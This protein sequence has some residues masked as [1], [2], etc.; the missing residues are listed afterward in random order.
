MN[1]FLEA[2]HLDNPASLKRVIGAG[3]AGLVVLLAPLIERYG[4]QKPSDMQLEIF[5]GIVVAW[6]LQ[7]GAHSIAVARA[8]GES[9]AE[10]VVTPEDAA[11]VLSESAKP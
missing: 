5:A 7:S 9:A 1:R 11:K 10:K 4:L 3:L 2:L 6:I 8:T